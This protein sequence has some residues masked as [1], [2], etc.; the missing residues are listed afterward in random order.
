[1]GRMAGI[2]IK[3]KITVSLDGEATPDV[4]AALFKQTVNSP[5]SSFDGSRYSDLPAPP[6][7]A[8]SGR[9]VAKTPHYVP[10]LPYYP[11]SAGIMDAGEPVLI[12]DQRT[13]LPSLPDPQQA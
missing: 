9:N 7:V 4:L 3:G 8:S 11:V 5:V 12:Q 13:R 6:L 1:M 10:S 2:P